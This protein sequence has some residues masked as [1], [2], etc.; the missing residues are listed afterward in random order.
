MFMKKLIFRP[1]AVLTTDHSLNGFW[2]LLPSSSINYLQFIVKLQ[3]A[4]K[5]PSPEIISKTSPSPIPQSPTVIQETPVSQMPHPENTNNTEIQT[6]STTTPAKTTPDFPHPVMELTI[7]KLPTLLTKTNNT[8]TT[9]EP[10]DF[11]DDSMGHS[12]SVISNRPLQTK[13]P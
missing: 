6:P 10:D 3:T 4:T 1:V 12:P 13:L 5:P 7:D 2:W 8:T 11:S 9:L